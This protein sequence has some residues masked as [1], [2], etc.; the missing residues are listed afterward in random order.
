ME[1]MVFAAWLATFHNLIA[2]DRKYGSKTM[3]FKVYHEKHIHYGVG[4]HYDCWFLYSGDEQREKF[5]N[6]QT[7]GG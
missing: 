7:E 5:N 3:F 4:R 1:W 6:R 2:K